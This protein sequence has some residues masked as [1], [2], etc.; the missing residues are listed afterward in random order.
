MGNNLERHWIM[1]V[2]MAKEAKK[3][4]VQITT[5]MLAVGIDESGWVH[6][7]RRV[8]LDY[9]VEQLEDQVRY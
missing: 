5:M 8:T 3:I 2:Q 1:M 7:W 9:L 6:L 4:L